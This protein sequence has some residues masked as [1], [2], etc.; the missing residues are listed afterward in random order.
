MP[1]C[2]GAVWLELAR[3]AGRIGR[4]HS[5][6]TEAAPEAVVPSF[7]QAMVAAPVFVTARKAALAFMGQLSAAAVLQLETTVGFAI[8]EA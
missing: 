4:W 1:G 3:V 6:I 7:T 8:P 5:S 2:E